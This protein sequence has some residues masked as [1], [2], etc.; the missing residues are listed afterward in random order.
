MGAGCVGTSEKLRLGI[1]LPFGDHLSDYPSLLQM[2]R[3]VEAA[4]FDTLWM[5]DHLTGPSPN[6]THKWFDVITLLSNLCAHVPRLVVGT[7]ILVVPHRHPVLTAKML[8]TLDHA[9]GGKLIVGTGVGYIEKEFAEL[10]VPFNERGAYTDECIQV[11]KAMWSPGRASFRGRYFQLE[12]T[13]SEPKPLQQPHPPIWVGSAAPPVLR[14]TV[15]LADGWHPIYLSLAQYEAGVATL[16]TLA[17]KAGRT[18]PL[19]LSYSGP[20]AWVGAEPDKSE[21]RLPLSGN[22]EQVAA[23]IERFI[24]LGVS[25]IVFRPG[26]M[27]QQRSVDEI[28]AQIEFIARHVLPLLKR[29]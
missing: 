16:K 26:S 23:D 1:T 29:A 13:A 20:Y 6:G 24:K 18:R 28:C 11:W 12:D 17:D 2:A 10:G 7:D 9:S 14:R 19:T 8:A 15:A 25:N 22:P 21:Q 3:T 27:T 4:G 5:A